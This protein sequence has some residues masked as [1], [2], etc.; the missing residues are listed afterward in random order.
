[1]APTATATINNIGPQFLRPE[2]IPEPTDQQ[3]II[4]IEIDA[5]KSSMKMPITMSK[6]GLLYAPTLRFRLL[7]PPVPAL[8]K[9]WMQESNSDIPPASS[10]RISMMVIT[11]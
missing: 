1:M 8:P 4:H 7:K 9:E 3:E 2:H 11:K 10:S 6:Y 5:L